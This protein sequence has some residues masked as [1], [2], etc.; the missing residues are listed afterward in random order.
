MVGSNGNNLSQGE[1]QLLAIARAMLGNKEFLLLD[2][3][4]SWIDVFTEK[5]DKML[6]LS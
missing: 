5:K 4:T 2:E 6:C 3:A 1:K